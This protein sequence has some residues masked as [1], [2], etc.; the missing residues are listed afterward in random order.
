M[1]QQAT[2]TVR[3]LKRALLLAR[4]MNQALKGKAGRAEYALLEMQCEQLL[5]NVPDADV[6]SKHQG[7]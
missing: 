6:A 4:A 5:A 7:Y 3:D 1:P 2:V